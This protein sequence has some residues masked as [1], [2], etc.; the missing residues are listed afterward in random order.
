MFLFA[1]PFIYSKCFLYF[2]FSLLSFLF[3]FFTWMRFFF[4]Y[5]NGFLW[6]L[7]RF[8]FLFQFSLWSHLA[9]LYKNLLA[10]ISQI[11]FDSG[12]TVW[13]LLIKSFSQHDQVKTGSHGLFYREKEVH[14][15]T[16][17]STILPTVMQLAR[18]V[19]MDLLQWHLL[20]L[21]S[22]SLSC[23]NLGRVCLS[24]FLQLQNVTDFLNIKKGHLSLRI[25]VWG[26]M[27]ILSLCE[28]SFFLFYTASLLPFPFTPAIFSTLLHGYVKRAPCHLELDYYLE[29]R[30]SNFE[31]SQVWNAGRRF[32]SVRERRRTPAVS[33][34]KIILHSSWMETKTRIE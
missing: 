24:P 23:L 14:F 10:Q 12:L 25:G 31:R 1:C 8:S 16:R 5:I 6:I 2:A 33:I 20:Y 18:D 21:R 22:F 28:L 27:R 32:A 9:R 4:S 29:K 11:Y 17:A 26:D 3:I 15:Y 30:E 7:L 34:V 13:Y 19:F